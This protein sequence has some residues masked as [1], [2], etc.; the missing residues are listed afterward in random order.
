MS[1]SPSPSD[2]STSQ[3]EEKLL[4]LD[5][6]LRRASVKVVRESKR[7]KLKGP[8]RAIRLCVLS[9]LIPG[10][11]IAVPLYMRFQVYREQMYPV[12]MSDMRLLDNRVSTT[13]CQKQ[14]VR[15]NTTFN[16]FLMPEQPVMEQEP[17]RVSM[18]RHLELEDDMKE[19]WAFYLLQGSSVTVS[20]C[21]RWPG[22]SLVV[23]RGH[24]HLHQCAYIG[25]DSSEELEEMEA[26]IAE[27]GKWPV[28]SVHDP[29][30]IKMV[31]NQQSDTGGSTNESNQ[32]SRMRRVSPGV[33]FHG[34][35]HPIN[36]HEKLSHREDTESDHVDHIMLQLLQNIGRVKARIKGKDVTPQDAAVQPTTEIPAS[37]SEVFE[38]VLRRLQK[39]GDRG[40]SVLGRLN[41]Q[42]KDLDSG[43]NETRDLNTLRNIIREM[44]HDDGSNSTSNR[45]KRG[46]TLSSPSLKDSLNEHDEEKDAA[47]EEDFQPD[48]IADHHETLNETTANDRSHS[49]FWSSFSSS[50]EKLLNCAGLILN[51]PLT[52]HSGCHQGAT[53]EEYSSAAHVNTLTYKIPTNGYYFFVFSSENEVQTNY[54]RVHFDLQKTVYNISNS[55]AACKNSTQQC[56]LPLDFF[57][58]EKVVLELPVRSNESLWNEEYIAVSTCEPRTALY[59]GCVIAVPLFILFFAFQ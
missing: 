20:T 2:G 19:Y 23:I 48:G 32:P 55:V 13:W 14:L 44:L 9:I 43:R 17:L 7:Q 28:V 46:I 53:Q 49:E 31:H 52:P 57:S 42:M 45:T 37:S 34:D 33:H 56:S 21:V 18:S 51:L 6:Q 59:L 1:T 50:E 15:A 16:A 4:P 27:H 39:L 11:L 26:N 22:A 36:S 25:D 24:K 38:D 12:G 47:L 54:L 8:L 41:D 10:L 40:R 29:N 30:H 5:V 3:A 35:Q 58:S